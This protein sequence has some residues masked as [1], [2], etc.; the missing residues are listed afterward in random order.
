MCQDTEI[1][2]Q[3]VA[4][5][6]PA[7]RK[8]VPPAPVYEESQTAAPQTANVEKQSDKAE[9]GYYALNLKRKLKKH[10]LH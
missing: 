7:P 10:R 9:G 1:V 3:D 6:I 4:G 8:P 2:S 5:T